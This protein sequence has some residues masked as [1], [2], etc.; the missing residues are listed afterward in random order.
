MVS[1]DASAARQHPINPLIYGIS[2][3]DADTISA[4]DLK[5]LNFTINRMGGNGLSTYNWQQNAHNLASDWFFESYPY[6]SSAPSGEADTF[7][8]TNNAANVSS[9]V[10][11]PMLAWIAKLGD[12]RSVLPAFSIKKYGAQTEH[13][14]WYP[15]AG[16]GILV[17][18]GNV[19]NNAPQD[20]YVPSTPATQKGFVQHL[21][22]AFGPATS[23]GP[24]F[25]LLD[26]EVSLWSSTHRDVHPEGVHAV[27][28]RD[29]MIDYAAVIRAADPSAKIVGPEEWGWLPF[30]YSG[31]D[32]VWSGDH[33][34]N[35]EPPDHAGVQ[36]GADY[37][38]WLLAEM[39]KAGRPI[40]VFSMHYYPQSG[41]YSDDMSAAVQRLRN[42][43]TRELWDPSYVSESWIGQKV[44]LIPRMKAL[45]KNNYY[46]GTPTAL[47]EYSWG[48]DGTISGATAQADVLGIFGREGLDIATRWTVP[49]TETPTFKAMQLYRNYD[50]NLHVFGETGVSAKVANPDEL[51][52]FAALRQADKALTVM[53]I[54]KSLPGTSGAASSTRVELK[55]FTPSGQVLAYQLTSK[56]TIA[57]LAA[58][59]VS[60]GSITVPTPAQ[61]VTM[62]VVAA[63]GTVVAEPPVAKFTA[64]PATLQSALPVSATTSLD[65][66]S[67]QAK[68]NPIASYAWTFGDGK[69]A[70][71][72]AVSHTYKSYGFFPLSLTVKDSKGLVDAR[73]IT[74]PV[75]PADQTAKTCAI[76]YKVTSDWDTGFVANLHITNTGGK[77]I[78][79]WA[80]NWSFAGNQVISN[81]WNGTLQTLGKEQLVTPADWT[82]SIGAGGSID[83]GFYADYTG[84]NAKPVSIKLNGMTCTLH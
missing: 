80:L 35:S 41:E 84:A 24:D 13:D 54:N 2:V 26:N 69:T 77:A 82:K 40:D 75:R 15:D 72:V 8:K 14:S 18:G 68:T 29:A 76:T 62:V 25:Y 57:R 6:A 44:N 9:M 23:K 16:N 65:A 51:S 5:R 49:H 22:T 47:T 79:G 45:V 3:G 70:S 58:P 43:S 19:K 71:G 7:V 11:V 63:K 67:S 59:K 74:V 34:W 78:N 20:A 38:A 1:V 36:K 32:Q 37:M 50:G 56:N 83:V 27:E 60:G 42:R 4:T 55:G 81:L 17:S 39:K 61:S 73:T 52:A 21:V 46:A 31:Y 12:Q 48:A 33:G 28:A 66:H 30:L 64:T 53:V 10:T